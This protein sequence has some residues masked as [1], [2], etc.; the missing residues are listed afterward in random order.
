MLGDPDRM[1]RVIPGGGMIRPSIVVNGRVAGTWGARRSGGAIGIEVELFDELDS[2]Q[3]ARLE[4]EIE[5]VG[6][7]EGLAARQL[8]MSRT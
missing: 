6:R 4:A 1:R 8:G 2:S 3:R 7:F 5:D